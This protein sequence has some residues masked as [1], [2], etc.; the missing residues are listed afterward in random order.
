M[1]LQQGLLLGLFLTMSG[2]ALAQIQ[3][4]SSFSLL[5][6][7]G[8][9]FTHA[10]DPHINRWLQKYG[11][12]AEPHVPSSLNF[13]IAAI[14]ASSNLLYSIKLSTITSGKNLSSFNVLGGLY[15]ALVHTKNLLLFGGMGAGYH[16]DILTLNGNMPD[17][18]KQLA[19]QYHVSLAL[20]RTGLFLEPALRA[21]WFPVTLHNVQVG[22]FGGLG[23]DL[24]FNSRWKL[25]YYSNNHGK[26]GHFKK[27]KKPDDQQRVSEYGIAYNL[28][29]TLRVNLH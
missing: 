24:D 16:D 13:E 12:P 4:D 25:G 15:T 18:Y 29:I 7:Q 14:P 5:F 21:F 26:Y 28:G 10:N 9:S 19:D 3:P 2:A 17:D 1:K 20:R 11:Y 8:I 23:Y 27:L 6:N 22:L